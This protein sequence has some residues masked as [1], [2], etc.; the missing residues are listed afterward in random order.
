MATQSYAWVSD[1]SGVQPRRAQIPAS[2]WER[3]RVEI[4]QEFEQHDLPHV[5]AYMSK[6]HGFNAEYGLSLSMHQERH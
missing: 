1:A 4:L 5:M 2:K 6:V 3:Y